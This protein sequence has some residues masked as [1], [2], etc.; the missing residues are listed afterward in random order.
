MKSAIL[1]LVACLLIF[2]PA[3]AAQQSYTVQQLSANFY[4]ARAQPGGRSSTNAF[5]F[6]AGKQVIAGGA[7]MSKGAMADLWSAV[8]TTLHLPI[9]TFIL[10]HHHSGFSQID[11]DFPA[12]VTLV[13]SGATWKSLDIEGRK[14]AAPLLLFSDG[15]TF[16]S[17]QGP[18]LVLSS[19]GAAHSDGDTIVVIPEQKIA[20]VGDLLYIKSV[21][22]MGDGHL[23]AW[24]QSL[25]FLAGL[26]MEQYVPG[27][28]PPVDSAGVNEFREYF[29]DFLS[30]VL[31]RIEA[32]ES[33]ASIRKNFTLPKY[34]KWSGYRQF[35]QDNAAH[36]WQELKKDYGEEL[37]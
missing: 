25:D 18:D 3:Q 10:T 27:Y 13:L 6:V 16:K 31:S 4:L 30:E 21:G 33:V 23:Q 7:H 28:G 22:Y 15:L 12:D 35:L 24:V 19:I 9:R 36:A 26:A 29:R 2:T 11:T 14:I 32:G 37:P 17:P 8:D 20:Y 5:F 34:Q 1:S